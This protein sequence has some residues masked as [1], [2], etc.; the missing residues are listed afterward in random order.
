MTLTG[1][2]SD[3]EYFMHFKL[4]V[5]NTYA[6]PF[7]R[8]CHCTP[9]SLLAIALISS[10]QSSKVSFHGGETNANLYCA[11][12]SVEVRLLIVLFY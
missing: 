5:L 9:L 1:I 2:V 10:T 6:S 12:A 8:C 3:Y 4:L 7:L 11:A